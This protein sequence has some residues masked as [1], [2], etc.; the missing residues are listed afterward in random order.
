MFQCKELQ[1]SLKVG[2]SIQ[3]LETEKGEDCAGTVQFLPMKFEFY[4]RY[5]FNS[6]D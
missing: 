3:D 2:W 6:T 4:L 5:S 1:T